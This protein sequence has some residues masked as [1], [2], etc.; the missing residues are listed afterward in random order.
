MSPSEKL[1]Q[2]IARKEALTNSERLAAAVLLDEL[3]GEL[4]RSYTTGIITALPHEMAAVEAT[5]DAVD[6]TRMR[7]VLFKIA[8]A[9]KAG[10]NSEQIV[11]VIRQTLDYGNNMAAICATEMFSCFP[12]IENVIMVGIAGGIPFPSKPERHVRLGDIVVSS[13]EGVTQYD[14]GKQEGD[15]CGIL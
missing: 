12:S 1:Q 5:F 13:Y 15:E 6:V 4:V 10:S 11:A 8:T 14:F 3:R 2:M 9:T 7:G